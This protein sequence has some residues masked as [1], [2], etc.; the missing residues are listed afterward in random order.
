MHIKPC[1][2]PHAPSGL[3][4]MPCTRGPDPFNLPSDAASMLASRFP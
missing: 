3:L 4:N 1:S 2:M